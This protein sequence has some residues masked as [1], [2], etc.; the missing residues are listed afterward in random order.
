MCPDAC[1]CRR[2]PSCRVLC[3]LQHP[4]ACFLDKKFSKIMIVFH[5]ICMGIFQRMTKTTS[6]LFLQEIVPNERPH[7][8]SIKK[9]KPLLI[10]CVSSWNSLR[11]SF[12]ESEACHI[13]I[14][15]ARI[16]AHN[17]TP[18]SLNS[19]SHSENGLRNNTAPPSFDTGAYAVNT[20][21]LH[22]AL[23]S[24]APA[25]PVFCALNYFAGNTCQ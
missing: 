25:V 9:F 18:N 12:L 10:S 22:R 6:I 21:Q 15:A 7:R 4:S 17:K 24:F 14:A 20:I 19:Q 1:R 5:T 2:Y 13:S 3:A 23:P 16:W 8:L 11:R